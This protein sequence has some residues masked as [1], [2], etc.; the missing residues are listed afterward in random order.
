MPL[1]V[2]NNRRLATPGK[3]EPAD[4]KHEVEP[5]RENQKCCNFFIWSISYFRMS[6]YFLIFVTFCCKE[7]SVLRGGVWASQSDDYSL[8]EE[9]A[10]K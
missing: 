9:N 5:Q 3:R 8:H 6:L 10:Y 1:R 7:L 2:G 4:Y